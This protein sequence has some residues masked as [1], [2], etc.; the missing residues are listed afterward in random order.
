[1]LLLCATPI[2]NLGDI[3]LRVRDALSVCDAIYCEDTRHTLTLLNHLQVKKPLVSCHQH[4]EAARAEEIASRLAAGETIVYVSDAGMPG[5]SDPGALLIRMCIER[6]LAYTVLPG[7]SAVTTAAVL[8]GFPAQPFT[9]YGFF[10]RE[11]KEQ[12]ALLTELLS[13]DHLALF[14]ESPNRVSA[15]LK[16]LYDALGDL[17]AAL[18][19]ELTKLHEEVRRGTLSSLCEAYQIEPPRGECVLAV[20]CKKR[21]KE[22]PTDAERDAYLA[23][24]LKEGL[25]VKDASIRAQTER[26][27]PKKEAY[28]LLLC[29][30]SDA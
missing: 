25:S 8:C 20:L 22:P 12:K 13:L 5:I 9:F 23:S 10:P 27:I 4:N 15:T 30:K 24:L 2:G 18:C 26:G 17:D 21:A 6:N 1:M 28:R 29:Q 11:K 19:R 14:Y 16:T 3:T 7:A